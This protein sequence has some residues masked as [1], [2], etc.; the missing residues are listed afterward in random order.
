MGEQHLSHLEPVIGQVTRG[1]FGNTA[2]KERRGEN[3]V[4]VAERR[5][6]DAV[7]KAEGVCAGGRGW[8]FAEGL[9]IGN[10]FEADDFGE[11]SWV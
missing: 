10:G 3:D 6:V 9:G 11:R 1:C 4:C 7:G 2:G 5:G 8:G